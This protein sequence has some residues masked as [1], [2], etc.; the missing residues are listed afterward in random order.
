MFDK[1]IKVRSVLTVLIFLAAAAF[2]LNRSL[3][4]PASADGGTVP[5]IVELRDEPAAVYKARIQRSGGS[6]TDEQL[7]AYRAQLGAQQEEFLKALSANGLS[8]TVV[9]RDIK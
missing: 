2:L 1:F 6:V 4:I 9:S 3:T 7:Q 8:F 5:V